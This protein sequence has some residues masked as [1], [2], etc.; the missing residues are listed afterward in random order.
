VFVGRFF[1]LGKV[2]VELFV[3]LTVFMH[4]S[5]SVCMHVCLCAYVRMYA[6]ICKP[7]CVTACVF[8]CIRLCFVICSIE[9]LKHRIHHLSSSFCLSE[10]IVYCNTWQH[11]MTSKE[12][13]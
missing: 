11:R 2:A 3:S 13:A 1:S 6:Y 10:A 12:R 8:M 9:L 4:V 7:V 5:P